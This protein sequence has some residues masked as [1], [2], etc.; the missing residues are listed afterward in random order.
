MTDDELDEHEDDQDE[1][2]RRPRR[3]GRVEVDRRVPVVL[4][5]GD[6][7]VAR[8]VTM[9]NVGLGGCVLAEALPGGTSVGI[10]VTDD[11]FVVGRVMPG[12][13]GGAR[14][15]WAPNPADADDLVAAYALPLE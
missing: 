11:L 15:E 6:E 9:L 14:I 8:E 13:A 4:V 3:Y 2:E 7:L 1:E 10:L 5:Q 12:T